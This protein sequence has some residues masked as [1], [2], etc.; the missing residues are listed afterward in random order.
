MAVVYSGPVVANVGAAVDAGIEL[1]GS[2]TAGELVAGSGAKTIVSKYP[3]GEGP[4][5]IPDGY[6]HVDV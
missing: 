1:T 6:A 3:E 4:E 5:S 2:T